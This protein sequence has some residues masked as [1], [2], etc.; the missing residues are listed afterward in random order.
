MDERCGVGARQARARA[1][2][3]MGRI[4]SRPDVSGAIPRARYLAPFFRRPTMDLCCSQRNA[5]KL[6]VVKR[7]CEECGRVQS[8]VRSAGLINCCNLSLHRFSPAPVIWMG[9]HAARIDPNPIPVSFFPRRAR[10]FARKRSR[11]RRSP[12][13]CRLWHR[14]NG[15]HRYR[16]VAWW[17]VHRLVFLCADNSYVGPYAERRAHALGLTAASFGLQASGGANVPLSA[18]VAASG[19]GIGLAGHRAQTFDATGILPGDLLI[20]FEP[21]HCARAAALLG[22]NKRA[23][24]ALLASG[25]RGGYEGVGANAEVIERLYAC[26]DQALSLMQEAWADGRARIGLR[27]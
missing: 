25:E 19:R 23:Q 16:T 21:A 15:H 10:H 14:W 1:L 11:R 24:V 9:A 8:F 7:L 20:G 2:P 6:E 17:S 12:P 27:R 13:L 22:R 26:I 4:R 5:P 3:A 18:L